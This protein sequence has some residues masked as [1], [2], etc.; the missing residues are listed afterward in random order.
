MTAQASGKRRGRS[1]RVAARQAPLPKEVK[2]V[3]PGLVGGRYLPLDEHGVRRIHETAL[4]LLEQVGMG[5]P[6]PSMIETCAAKGAWLNEEGRLCFPRALV[7]DIV[8]IAAKRFV[9]PGFDPKHD[10]E[11]G[12]ARVHTGTGGAAPEIVDF[13]TGRYRASTTTD[14]YDIARLVDTLD[15]IHFYW[16]SVVA[17]DMDEALA[18]DLNTAYAAMRGTSKHIGVSYIRGSHVEEAVRMFDMALGGE[19]RFRA[20]PFCTIS[21]CHVVPPLRFAVESCD[22]LEAAVR[23]GMTVLLLSAGQAGA[24]S[25]AALAGSVAQAVAEVLAGLVF[26]NLIKP[27]APALFGTWPFVSDL[28]T[29]AMSGGSAEQ[30]LLMAA[31]A[32]MAN[33]YDMPGSVAA[34]MADSKIPDAQA[35]AEKAYTTVLA[36]Q[37]GASMIHECA[38]MHASLLGTCL[39]SYVIDND[40]L[41]SVLRTVRGIEVNDDTLAFDTIARVVRSPGHYLGENETLAGMERDYFYPTTFDRSTPAVWQGMG[42][43]DV[44]ERARWHVQ[45]VLSRHYPEHIERATDAALR[46]AFDIRV[47]DAVT[48]PDESR[49]ARPEGALP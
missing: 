26:V 28:R 14:L 46:A 38:G 9:L 22:A 34:G 27:G 12:G 47:D 48:H 5:D 6:V 20:R 31:S 17:R 43:A 33:F 35:G 45:E 25:P 30:A 19:G 11:V 16:R 42:G 40:I 3:R 21:C 23:A 41:G 37:A 49:W 2:P 7:E 1:A 32:Q 4:D 18:F 13:A 10:L 36:A 15:H 44:R 29:G 39:E 8:A 24:T